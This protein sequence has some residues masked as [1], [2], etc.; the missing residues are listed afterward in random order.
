MNRSKAS[1]NLQLVIALIAALAWA[2]ASSAGT[3]FVSGDTNI[4][5]PLVGSSGQPVDPGNV[6]F[7]KNVLGSGNTVLVLESTSVGSVN[8]ADGDLNDF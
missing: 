5:N 2:Q 4:V 1:S 3:I 8:N 7:F 6:Q